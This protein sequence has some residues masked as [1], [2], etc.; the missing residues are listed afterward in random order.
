MENFILACLGLLI[1]TVTV[2]II[3]ITFFDKDNK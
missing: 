2:A 3:K 1:L